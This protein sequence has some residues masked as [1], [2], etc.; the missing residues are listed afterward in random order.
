MHLPIRFDFI[1]YPLWRRRGAPPLH[2]LWSAFSTADADT[3]PPYSPAGQADFMARWRVLPPG[4][5]AAAARRALADQPPPALALP[6]DSAPPQPGMPPLRLPA[7]WQPIEAVTIV[8]PALYPPLWAGCF[9]MIEAIAPVARV[10]V[11][12]SHPAWAAVAGLHLA[13]RARVNTAAVRFIHLPTDDI[14]VRDYGAIIGHTPTG[15]RA[16]LSA[17]YDPLA[18]NYP[19]A[20]DDAMP[21]RYAG[22]LSLPWAPLELHTEGGNL[23]SDGAGTLL[24]SDDLF[25]RHPGMSRDAVRKRLHA[26]IAFETLITVPPLRHEETGH[27]DL[28]LKLAGPRTILLADSVAFNRDRLA[29]ARARVQAARNAQGEPY[30][31]FTLPMPPPYLNWGAFPVWRSYTNALTVN[32]R[33]IVPTFGLATDAPALDIYRR[34]MPGYEMIGVNCAAAA[35]G[36]GAVHCLTKEVP[37]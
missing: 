24:M 29:E 20:R 35:N 15:G 3:H 34:A 31:L 1:P 11:L 13:A 6:P 32:G 8:F 16:A 37:A 12:V 33:V 26:A 19:Q 28:A 9:A 5:D 18:G 7:Q 23:W 22:L 21:P 36:G 27:I 30:E 25:T 10:D 2:P 17:I 14:W 4:M